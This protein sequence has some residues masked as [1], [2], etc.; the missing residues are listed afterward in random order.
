MSMLHLEIVTP[1]SR[2]FSGNASF[3]VVPGVE[4]ELGI[5]P[6]H[7]PL[8]TEIRPGELAVTTEEGEKIFAV[9]GGFFE[10]RPDRVSVLTDMALKDSEID[11]SAAAE[12]VL[13]AER[14]IG[15]G[16]LAGEELATVQ[17][18]LLR[19]LAQLHVKRR[20]HR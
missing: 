17:A 3:V 2:V 7:I 10:V 18:S 6:E 14:E 4:G 5:L 8:L 19:S 16:E 9:G 13:L 11:E 12:A 20:T 15:K 1:E